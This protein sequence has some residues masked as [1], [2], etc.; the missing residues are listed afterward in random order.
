MSMFIHFFCLCP[1]GLAINL[2]FNI[3]K[4]SHRT[5]LSLITITN[6]QLQ[7]NWCK[8]TLVPPMLDSYSD[9]LAPVRPV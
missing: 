7:L 9:R 5:P 2:N 8:L 6:R 3:S 4:V 1:L